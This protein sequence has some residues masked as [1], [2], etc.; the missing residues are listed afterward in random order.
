MDVLK[1]WME[2]REEVV[3]ENAPYIEAPLAKTEYPGSEIATT[4]TEFETAMFPW[5]PTVP[6]T[7][8]YMNYY[9]NSTQPLV[10][11]EDPYLVQTAV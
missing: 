4:A 7:N 5:D 9:M 2:Q 3:L 10:V 1:H 11:G 6:M 8:E